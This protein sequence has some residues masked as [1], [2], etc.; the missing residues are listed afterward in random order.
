MEPLEHAGGASHRPGSKLRRAVYFSTAGRD[1]GNQQAWVRRSWIH[2]DGR[3]SDQ[4]ACRS[5]CWY[6]EYPAGA[7]DRFWHRTV[8]TDMD[9]SDVGSAVC[10]NGTGESTD[11]AARPTRTQSAW[12]RE[13]A[14]VRR[15][16]TLLPCARD[17]GAR[18]SG[19]RQQIHGH[20]TVAAVTGL[21]RRR[22][23]RCTW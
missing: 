5:G 6:R 16:S 20:S 9:M 4:I 15:S 12:A 11:D 10:T 19:G 22:L 18:V 1:C 17:T 2:A 23:C 14:G 13:K 21:D 8:G 7:D 3:R